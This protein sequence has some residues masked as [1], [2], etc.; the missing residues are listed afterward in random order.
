MSVRPPA[1]HG[2]GG[3]RRQEFTARLLRPRR[4]CGTRTSCRPETGW[5][6]EAT[7]SMLVRLRLE[8]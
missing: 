2:K 5:M 7:Y 3:K 4:S 1:K 8:L 6:D